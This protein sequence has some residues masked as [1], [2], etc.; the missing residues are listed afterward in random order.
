VNWARIALVI[1]FV[2][3]VQ[4]MSSALKYS[5]LPLCDSV[6]EPLG[7]SSHYH[8]PDWNGFDRTML[9]PLQAFITSRFFAAAVKPSTFNL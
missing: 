6:I 4:A 3:G 7:V 9:V 5:V 1:S 8:D 2:R